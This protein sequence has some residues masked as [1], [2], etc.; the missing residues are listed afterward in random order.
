LEISYK[1]AAYH[2][3][4]KQE[5]AKTVQGELDRALAFML[6]QP[7]QSI[8]SGRT[9]T[10]VHCKSQ[11]VHFDT[12]A[13]VPD[14]ALLRFQVNKCLPPDIAVVQIFPVPDTANARFSAL[15]RRYEY[16]ITTLK[17]PLLNGLAYYYP[18]PLQ[19]EAMNQAASTLLE[20]TDFEAFSRVKTDVKTF[21]CKIE[22]AYWE[23]T[24]S[25][26]IFHIKADRF[27]RGMVRAIVGTLLDVGR[28]ALEPSEVERILNTRDRTQAGRAVPAHGL[29]LAEVNYPDELLACVQ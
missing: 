9:D 1:G 24:S 21:L 3:W 15:S 5:N 17:A 23:Q 12:E 13:P 16:H 22:F 26:L 29:Y 14:L 27:L 6:R 4:Q 11:F 25:M 2:G 28:G 8:G 18:R 10:G 7:V 19:M 20:H